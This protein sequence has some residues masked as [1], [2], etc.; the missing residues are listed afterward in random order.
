MEE[1]LTF[2]LKD[3]VKFKIGNE[4]LFGIVTSIS[5]SGKIARVR[6]I[7]HGRRCWHEWIKVNSIELIESRE[8]A[9]NE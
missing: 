4:Y 9:V 5:L 7:K 2:K 8:E 1:H 6:I 3:Q